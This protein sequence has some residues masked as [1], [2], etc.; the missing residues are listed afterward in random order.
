M[1]K[2]NQII[3]NA[4]GKSDANFLAYF[5]VVVGHFSVVVGHFSVVVGHFSVTCRSA[6][7]VLPQSSRFFIFSFIV[8]NSLYALN[9]LFSNIKEIPQTLPRSPPVPKNIETIFKE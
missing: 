9:K 4:V 8:P 7:E 2:R 3:S 6:I 1:K 5:S